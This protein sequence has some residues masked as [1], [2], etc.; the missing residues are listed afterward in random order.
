VWVTATGGVSATG[1]GWDVGGVGVTG[2]AGVGVDGGGAGAGGGAGVGVE[3]GSEGGVEGGVVDGGVGGGL[4][5]SG[6]ASPPWSGVDPLEAPLKRSAPFGVPPPRISVAVPARWPGR[7][8]RPVGVPCA[9]PTALPGNTETGGATT[10]D[11]ACGAG[12]VRSKRCPPP[13]PNERGSKNAT[14]AAPTNR[15]IVEMRLIELMIAFQT[16]DD[17]HSIEV[18]ATSPFV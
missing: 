7:P 3:G 14:A 2:G 10:S 11:W 1:G 12:A 17:Y 9:P 8:E 18:S 5:C 15:A 4:G 13:P 16:A 6:R